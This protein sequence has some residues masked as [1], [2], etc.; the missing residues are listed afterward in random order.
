MQSFWRSSH[1]EQWLL[2]KQDLTRERGEDVKVLGE[3][4]YQKLLIFFT[5]FIQAI[6][7]DR[8]VQVRMQAIA[9]ACVYFRR[10]Y[11]RRSL[12]DIDPF[13]LA[14]ACVSVASKVE[15]NGMISANKIITAVSNALKRWPYLPQEVTIRSQNLQEAEFYILE[16]MD[17]C[18]IV[19][20]PYRPLAQ[21]VQDL[22]AFPVKEIEP[23]QQDAWRVCNDILRSDIPLLYPPHMI[24]CAA[25][26]VA[27]MINGK[28]KD[29]KNWLSELAVD[30]EKIF[31]IQQSIFAMYRLWKTFDEKEQLLGLIEKMPKPGT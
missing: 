30:F 18:L 24:A 29:V 19:Y 23:I 1:F 28:E 20:Q 8:N 16:I 12:K 4:D 11:S 6:G 7:E 9:T 3:E 15:E 31:E 26:I 17:C 25:V 14:P 13:L 22:K 27:T 2:D 5:N 21:I 10:F